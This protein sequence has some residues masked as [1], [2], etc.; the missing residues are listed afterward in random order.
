MRRIARTVCT[1]L[2]VV[3]AS[4]PA[5]GAELYN[6][7]LSDG[8]EVIFVDG[9]ITVGDEEKFRELTI[10][11]KS[12]V[13]VLNSPGGVLKPALEIGRQVRLRGYSTIIL[14]EREC[15]SACALIWLAGT[16]RIISGSGRVGF[17]ASYIDEGG[18]KVESGVANAMVGF[19]LSQLNL[20]ENAVI[21]ATL[22]PPDEVKWITSESVESTPI[23]FTVWK[24]TNNPSNVAA[25]P[26]IETRPNIATAQ[27]P[28][29]WL[30]SVRQRPDFALNEAKA[31]GAQGTLASE[32]AEHISLIFSN[33][34]VLRRIAQELEV[35]KI[36]PATNPKAAAV[37]LFNLSTNSQLKG[38]KRLPQSD[39]DT[40]IS[41]YSSALELHMED[42][43]VILDIKEKAS[44]SE[45]SAIQSLGVDK[46]QTYLRISRAALFAE[47]TDYPKPIELTPSQIEIAEEAYSKNISAIFGDDQ[48][49]LSRFFETISN[50]A[51]SPKEDVCPAMYI[52][53]ETG[54]QMEGLVGQWMRRRFMQY[55]SED[56]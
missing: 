20:S 38:L 2:L 4:N 16:R 44:S 50:Y 7:T 12:A 33:D 36:D 34:A 6:D 45:F 1:A 32:L 31:I 49:V 23:E 53:F 35:A 10:K 55:M 47:I 29:Q 27:T 15:A 24:D 19:Y 11:Y 52:M 25:P 5:S 18:R 39:V 14:E 30:L 51:D 40:Y 37:I 48:S 41:I 3:A 56:L 21:F 17:H 46:L 28:Y 9:E 26:P 13:V 42:C 43:S 54:N 8:T 22:A